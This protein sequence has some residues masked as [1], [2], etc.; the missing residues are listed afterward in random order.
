MNDFA[1]R[2]LNA[3]TV[4]YEMGCC[5]APRRSYVRSRWHPTIWI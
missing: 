4:H 5:G 3:H 1:Q 2:W